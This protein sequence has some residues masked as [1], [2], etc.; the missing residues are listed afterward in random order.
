MSIGTENETAEKVKSA[1]ESFP[2]VFHAPAQ[3]TTKNT[4]QKRKPPVKPTKTKAVQKIREQIIKKAI[5]EGK[6]NAEA[7]RLAGYAETTVSSKATEIVDRVVGKSGGISAVMDEAGI[8][9]RKLVKKLAEGLDATKVIS[10]VLIAPSGEEMKEASGA[11]KDFIEVPDFIARHKY[12]E[13]GLKLRG[14]LKN[15]KL[16]SS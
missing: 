9:D 10:A 13:S 14:H 4:P 1:S 6:S 8:S 11:T 7:C 12:I 5:I 16:K 15:S 3:I 2:S